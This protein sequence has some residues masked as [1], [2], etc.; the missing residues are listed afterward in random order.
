MSPKLLKIPRII[1]INKKFVKSKNSIR[2]ILS[3]E[4][5]FCVNV[6]IK[7]TKQ[8]RL[9]KTLVESEVAQN[10]LDLRN[11]L[12]KELFFFILIPKG[13]YEQNP[14]FLSIP[15]LGNTGGGYHLGPN[16]SMS[17]CTI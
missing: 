5:D 14:K 10:N 9:Y 11:S 6:N 1:I 13:A 15:N 7:I 2:S 4:D 8:D 12:K 17:M 16:V 3:T